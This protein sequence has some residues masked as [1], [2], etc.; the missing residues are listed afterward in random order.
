MEETAIHNTPITS[1]DNTNNKRKKGMGLSQGS[2]L[3]EE[4]TS[5]S[6]FNNG[7]IAYLSCAQILTN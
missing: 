3:E 7:L 5:S 4:C 6:F 2:N 1:K